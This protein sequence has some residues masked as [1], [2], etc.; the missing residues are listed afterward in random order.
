[1]TFCRHCWIGSH[2]NRMDSLA[3]AKRL[4]L[5]AHAAIATFVT[6]EIESGLMFCRIAKGQRENDKRNRT[7]EHVRKAIRTAEN[8]MQKLKITHAE[9]NRIVAHLELLKFELRN[10]SKGGI[11]ARPE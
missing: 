6:V 3:E 4:R 10:I 1:M 2:L 7:L 5:E 9:F 11:D 8:G